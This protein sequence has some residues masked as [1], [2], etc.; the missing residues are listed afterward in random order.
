MLGDLLD[1]FLADIF[2]EEL[3]A[4]HEHTATVGVHVLI[5]HLLLHLQPGGI[6]LRILVLQA[7]VPGLAES[8]GATHQIDQVASGGPMLRGGRALVGDLEGV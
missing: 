3:G 8:D 7:K 1:Q 5:Q 6:V 4:E 2:R